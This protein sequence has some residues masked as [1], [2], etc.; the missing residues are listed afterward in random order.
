M[1]ANLSSIG[2][3]P[4]KQK[5]LQKVPGVK[6]AILDFDIEDII[7]LSK[8]AYLFSKSSRLQPS[9]YKVAMNVT[10]VSSKIVQPD[11]YKNAIEDFIYA[12]H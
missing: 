12:A 9:I 6:I 2:H 8:K 11:T 5:K 7:K 3:A 10:R 1:P 4:K